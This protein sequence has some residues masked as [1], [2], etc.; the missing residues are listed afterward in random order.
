[1]GIDRIDRRGSVPPEALAPTDGE[2]RTT[3][4]SRSGGPFEPR[5]AVPL[6]PVAGVHASAAL[7]A[8]RAGRLDVEGYIDAKVEEATAH[9]SH[10][11]PSHL[12]AVRGVVRGQ[13]LADPHLA[14]LVERA[15]GSP[16][17]AADE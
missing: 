13:L 17:P 11:A 7:E 8:V 2:S 10:L 12:A 9:L 1:M 6:Q 4:L 14:E 3:R 16:A 15:T 5:P